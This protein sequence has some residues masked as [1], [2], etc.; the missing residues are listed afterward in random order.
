MIEYGDVIYSAC[1]QNLLKRLQVIQNTN[2]KIVKSRAL[3]PLVIDVQY[4]SFIILSET[5]AS[6]YPGVSIEIISN[7]QYFYCIRDLSKSTDTIHIQGYQSKLK[8]MLF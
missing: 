4:A 2:I 5:W 6:L 8:A 3:K 7:M 1:P